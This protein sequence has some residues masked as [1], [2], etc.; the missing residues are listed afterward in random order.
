VIEVRFDASSIARVRF[1]GSP[2]YEAVSWLAI[3]RAGQTHPLLGDPGAAARF[4]LR[5]RCVATAAAMVL[6]WARA[7]YMP[8]FLTPKPPPASDG[9]ALASQLDHVSST[10]PECLDMQLEYMQRHT[11]LAAPLRRSADSGKL[12]SVVAAGLQR[13]WTD[14]LAEMWPSLQRS[15]RRDVVRQ[16][17]LMAVGGTGTVLNGLHRTLRWSDGTMHIDKPYRETIDF[18]NGELVLVPSV[19]GPQR[20]AAQVWNPDDAML[21]YPIAPSDEPFGAM[22][23]DTALLG[24]GRAAVLRALRT[25]SSTTELRGMLGL[26]ASTISHHLQVLANAGLATSTRQ[27]RF[28]MYQQTASGRALLDS[29]RESRSARY[30]RSGGRHRGQLAAPDDEPWR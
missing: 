12:A 23:S 20:M 13:F 28:V 14:V 18:R 27:G 4:A 16:T 1:A 30:R 7:Q 24:A 3:T 15:I 22:S 8:D 11:P 25:P 10:S 29:L 5:D 17:A 21:A 9:W 2:V 19:L 26:S 6:P